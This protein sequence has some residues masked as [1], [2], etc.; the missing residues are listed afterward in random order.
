MLENNFCFN[1]EKSFLYKVYNCL[2]IQ[3][4]WHFLNQVTQLYLYKF[5]LDRRDNA[6][7]K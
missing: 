2:Q 4:Y 3:K 1:R 6:F 7:S 5:L